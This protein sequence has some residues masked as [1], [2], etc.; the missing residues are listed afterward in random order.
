MR[1]GNA[2][3]VFWLVATFLAGAY[4]NLNSN[5]YYPTYDDAGYPKNC[6][7]VIEANLDGY[8]TGKF[9]AEDAL[10]SVERNCGAHGNSW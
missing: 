5:S 4:L 2:L 8:H 10:A 3:C 1:N 7:A 6:R 9:S